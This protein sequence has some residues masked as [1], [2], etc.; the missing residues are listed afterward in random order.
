MDFRSRRFPAA[1]PAPL[2]IG[3]LTDYACPTGDGTPGNC[4]LTNTNVRVHGAEGYGNPVLRRGQVVH[5]SQFRIGASAPSAAASAMANAR[6]RRKF[7]AGQTGFS[8][9]TGCSIPTLHAACRAH[10]NLAHR[11]FA[12]AN[13]SVW[14]DFRC[15]RTRK[16]APMLPFQVLATDGV[17]VR[18]E[19]GRKAMRTG[20]YDHAGHARG[21]RHSGAGRRAAHIF[22]AMSRGPD[23]AKRQRRYLAR[24]S[25]WR[26]NRMGQARSHRYGGSGGVAASR[27]RWP[28]H[29]WRRLI[30]VVQQGDQHRYSAALARFLP[31]DTRVIYFVHRFR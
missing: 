17:S 18:A 31:G 9:L 14:A 10:G 28:W 12:S 2:P 19:A 23:R 5:H 4:T 1:P 6:L 22:C 29:P 11:Q 13:M 25:T 21:N 15:P 26:A 24:M 7:G 16:A 27:C 20:A 30:P 8:R 3:A